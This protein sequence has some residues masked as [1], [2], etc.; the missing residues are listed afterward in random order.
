[1]KSQIRGLSVANRYRKPE[2]ERLVA[3][4]VQVFVNR[5]GGEGSTLYGVKLALG[6]RLS[7]GELRELMEELGNLIASEKLDR[8]PSRSFD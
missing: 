8:S 2:E 1:L 3:E 7:R 5:Y 6:R 4:G